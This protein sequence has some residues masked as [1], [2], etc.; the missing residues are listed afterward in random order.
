[1]NATRWTRTLQLFMGSLALVG[2]MA[3]GGGEPAEEE[4][5]AEAAP[6]APAAPTM[7]EAT[8]VEAAQLATG[9][10]A[11]EGQTVR[12][13]GLAVN[14]QVGT[15]AVFVNLPTSPAPT[16]FLI[17]F[18]APPVPAA[19]RS[20]DVVGTVT[21]VTPELVN[22]WVSSGAITENDRLMVEFASH[23]LESQAVQPAGM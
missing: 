18:S 8:V 5:A 2:V 12:V 6:E 1:M 10:A 3:C 15:S 16:P 23:Y 13:N 4:P 22:G 9:A 19:G 14:S 17:H 11:L 20:I 21:P 7:P